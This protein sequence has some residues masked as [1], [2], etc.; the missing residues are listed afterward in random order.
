ML[1]AKLLISF[2]ATLAAAH[3]IVRDAATRLHPD[4]DPIAAFDA[5]ENAVF[6]GKDIVNGVTL[7]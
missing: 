5:G 1:T 2:A 3:T 7:Y 6:L 4:V